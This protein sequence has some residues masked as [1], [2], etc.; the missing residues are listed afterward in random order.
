MF[1][2]EKEMAA[3]FIENLKDNDAQFAVIEFG[4][5]AT[6]KS[7]LGAEKDSRKLKASVKGISRSGDGKGLDKALEQAVQIFQ[8]EARPGSNRVLLVLTNAKSNSR[9]HDLKR[10]AQSLHDCGVKVRV[11]AVGNEINEDELQQLT[12]DEVPLL[13]VQPYEEPHSVVNN[14]AWIVGGE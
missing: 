6:I 11:I 8:N 10:H 13:R 2:K 4:H 3:S 1:D 14:A 9:S 7:K 12:S 5:K